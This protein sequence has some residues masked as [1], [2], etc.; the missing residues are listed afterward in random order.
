LYLIDIYY[1]FGNR[2][3]IG[4]NKT[5]SQELKVTAPA[6]NNEKPFSYK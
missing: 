3:A 6:K 2:E 4:H 5:C 1:I